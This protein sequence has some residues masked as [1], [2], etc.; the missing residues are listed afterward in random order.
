MK[1]KILISLLFLMLF[2]LQQDQIIS[3]CENSKAIA[4]IAPE[5][6]DA[7]CEAKKIKSF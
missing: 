4:D 2:V 7:G 6:I 3:V 5:R 1:H